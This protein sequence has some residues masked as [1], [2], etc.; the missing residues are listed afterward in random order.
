MIEAMAARH[1]GRVMRHEITTQAGPESVWRAWT[2]MEKLQQWFPD[3]AE[4]AASAGASITWAFD[5][6]GASFAY[7]VLEVEPGRRLL[8]E[9]DQPGAPGVLLEI[10][11]SHGGGS[12][13]LQL[14]ASGFGEGAAWD[15]E[16][17]GT[18]SGWRAVLAT[19]REYLENHFGQNRWIV[20]VER[21]GR[22][23]YEPLIREYVMGSGISRWLTESGQ[24][25]GEGSEFDLELR[26]GGR[27]S[28]RVLAVTKREIPLYWREIDG[29]LTLIA[30]PG[31]NDRRL[32]VAHC[33]SWSA[34]ASRAAVGSAL[35]LALDRLIMVIGG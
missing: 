22:F 25:G 2:E 34:R 6:W 5:S 12:T 9:C 8:L 35:G 21:A 26:D 1:R 29:V 32:V 28:G 33:S 4:G 15:D 31:G 20:K 13:T 16:Y 24:L 19:M 27:F 10:T 23:E 30:T 7:R 17:E 18:N 14:V 11:L 3:R